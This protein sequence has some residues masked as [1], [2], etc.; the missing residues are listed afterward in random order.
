M[1]RASG[2]NSH[3]QKNCC[4]YAQ[5]ER[6]LTSPV[7]VPMGKVI[8]IW[9]RSDDTECRAGIFY[10]PRTVIV[11]LPCETKCPRS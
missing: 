7:L 11:N 5:S 6:Q 8:F 2:V 9:E 3:M 1:V 4:V 10:L